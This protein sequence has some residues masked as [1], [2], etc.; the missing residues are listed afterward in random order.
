MAN[1]GQEAEDLC[2]L[3]GSLVI[4]M[5]TATPE[6]LQNN[7]QALRAYNSVGG[8]VVLDPVG[9]GATAL[10]RDTVKTLMAGGYFDLI[11]G[12]EGEVKTVFGEIGV[13]QH[14]VDSGRSTLDSF[15][16]ATLVKNLA[17]RERNIALMTGAIDYVSD[18]KRT[19]AIRN[20]HEYL[21]RITGG[22]CV[23]GTVISA[24]LAVYREDKLIATIAGLLHYEIAAEIAA[25]REDVRGPGTFVPALIDELH[26]ISNDALNNNVSWL[27]RA[28]IELITA[29]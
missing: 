11:K 3:G 26:R 27:S 10:R 7:L 18:G 23:L 8:P 15:A 21:G 20:G 12:N 29:N 17:A 6:G 1:Y 25:M 24:M 9:G 2:K 16:K 19:Y 5:G 13:Q 14:G 28:R 22:G 4:N